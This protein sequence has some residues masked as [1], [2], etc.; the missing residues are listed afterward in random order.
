MIAT[1]GLSSGIDG[2]LHVVERL[3][4]RGRAQ[5]V[6]L[7]MEYD[8]KPDSDYARASLADR[9]LRRMFGRTLRLE[10]PGGGG[11]R[12]LRTEGSAGRWQ[13]DWEV[14][15]PTPLPELRRALDRHLREG[16]WTPRGEEPGGEPASD[17]RF[18]DEERRPWA[19]RVELVP[20]PA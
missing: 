10:L 1:A 15:S 2:A 16:G 20:A 8:W 12:V 17:W 18:V 11:S 14:E 4:G 19:A 13:A 3:R 6:A 5:Q 7:N 9:H